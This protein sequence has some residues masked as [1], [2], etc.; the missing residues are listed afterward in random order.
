[1]KPE[2]VLKPEFVEFI[3]EELEI[4]TLYVSPKYRTLMHL[5][6]CG[7]GRKV[8]T[9]L[10]PAAWKLT[11]DGVSI[12]LHPSIGNWNLPCKSHYWIDRNRV[13]W[14]GQWTLSQI[15]AGHEAEARARAEYYGEE[16]PKTEP[17]PTPPAPNHSK[18]VDA[19]P[20]GGFWVRLWR[21]L[22]G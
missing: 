17:Q 21:R 22:F 18:P 15:Q 5:C 9:P 12:T 7:C 16:L 10:S 8:V 20:P 11:F 4:E 6:C 3:P 19:S 14:A 1:M 13:V 2:I